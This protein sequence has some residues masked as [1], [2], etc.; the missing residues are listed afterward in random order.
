[1]QGK[2]AS[3]VKTLGLHELQEAWL[4]QLSLELTFAPLPHQRLPHLKY[5]GLQ[6]LLPLPHMGYMGIKNKPRNRKQ[7]GDVRGQSMY[8]NNAVDDDDDDDVKLR[9]M[10]FPHLPG[11]GCWIVSELSASPPLPPPPPPPCQSSSRSFSPILFAKLLA[12]PHS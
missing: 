2:T 11:E 1:M 9:D 5:M 7:C 8:D 6:H 10:I 4:C 3:S 12:N